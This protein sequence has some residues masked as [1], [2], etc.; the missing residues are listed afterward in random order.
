M[1]PAKKAGR[2]AKAPP[3]RARKAAPRGAPATPGRRAKPTLLTRKQYAEHRG[4]SRQ[5]VDKAIRL[6]RISL[7][8]RMIDREAADRDWQANTDQRCLKP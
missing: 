7:I 2:A 5:S 8:G 6:G 3:T 4:I 1:R